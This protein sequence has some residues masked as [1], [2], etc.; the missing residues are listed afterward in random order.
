MLA[1]LVWAPRWHPSTIGFYGL[2]RITHRPIMGCTCGSSIS[3]HNSRTYK[4][5]IQTHPLISRGHTHTH[6][7]TQFAHARTHNHSRTRAR[8]FHVRTHPRDRTHSH[9]HTHTHTDTHTHG[10]THTHTHTLYQIHTHAISD[11]IA[12]AIL[13]ACVRPS[14]KVLRS[15]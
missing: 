4:H 14:S 6:T 5:T 15:K 8:T 1:L 3:R 11:E 7:I 2:G 13:T 10:H 12:R 9:A